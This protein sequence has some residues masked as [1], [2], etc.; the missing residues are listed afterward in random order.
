MIDTITLKDDFTF[1]VSDKAGE[2]LNGPQGHG[3]YFRDT[4][5][6]SCLELLVNGQAP[7]QLSYNADYNISATFQLST[8][9]VIQ[10]QPPDVAVTPAWTTVSHAIGIAR[11][12]F[13]RR[14]L[15][16]SLEFCNYHSEP[17]KIN[18][19]LRVGADFADIFEVRGFIRKLDGRAAEMGVEKAGRQVNFKSVPVNPVLSPRFLHFECDHTP[20][21]F[22]LQEIVSPI[23]GL[24][25]PEVILYYT[26][27][28]NPQQPL[29]L[30][31]MALPDPAVAQNEQG[32]FATSTDFKTEITHSRQVFTDW[33]RACTRVIT[34]NYTLDRIFQISMLDLRSLMQQ[35]PQGLT[36]TAGLP[37]YFTLFGRDSLITSIQTLGLNPQIAVDSLR[38]LAAYQATS[39]DD[40]R[41]SEPGKILHELRR[42]DMTLSGEMPHSPYYGSVDSTLLFILCFAETLK[43]LDDPDFFAEM[44]PAVE[45]AVIWAEKYGDLDGDG[46]IE[47]ARRSTRGILHQGWKDSDESLGGFPGP[48]PI[49]PIAL[50]EVQGYN[51]AAK[52]ALAETLRRYGDDDQKRLANRLEQEAAQLKINFNRDFWMEKEGFLGQALDGKKNL[53]KNI[54]SSPGHCLW[55]GI[56]DEAKAARMV[57][58]L[59]EPDMLS[60][61]GIRTMSEADWTYNPMSYHNGSI[62]PHDNALII[63]GLRRYGFHAEALRAATQL[64]EAAVTFG[65]YRLP[66]LYCGFPRSEAGQPAPVAYPVSCSP[67]AWAAGTP[68]LLLQTLLG[69]QA[70]AQDKT[71]SV[72]PILF[73]GID[74]LTLYGLRIGR[75]RLDL[76][77]KREPT[78]DIVLNEI[79]KPGG[80]STRA[81]EITVR[82]QRSVGIKDA[83]LTE[84]T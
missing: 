30:S 84:A 15:V 21:R 64:L 4:R 24:I 79:G 42:G 51:Y 56:V 76:S 12:R 83:H 6:L 70:D 77:F 5:Y 40:W 69:L 80:E 26:L 43:W 2:V 73:E 62:W 41:D 58:R 32:G 25:V 3:L 9:H 82:L 74:H 27:E 17:L 35:E 71:L 23:N 53:V 8:S 11:R 72:D 29:T 44:W 34:G 18:L 13:I 61:W 50:V 78:G 28:L 60:G 22:E 20:E 38:A 19:A 45:K 75:S 59:M 63:A 46:Y 55:S 1:L 10:L 81:Q 33:E 65:D 16:E 57:E 68:A 36:V 7:Q 48:R 67:Q 52:L 14:G 54:S 49:V 47:F 39:F 31:L 37:W 66:E